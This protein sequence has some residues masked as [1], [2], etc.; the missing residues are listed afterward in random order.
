MKASPFDPEFNSA[1]NGDT[2]IHGTSFG[3]ILP[4]FSSPI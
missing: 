1:S 4:G 2:F 3:K